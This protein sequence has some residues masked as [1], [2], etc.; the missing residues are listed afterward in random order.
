VTFGGALRV[1]A[2]NKYFYLLDGEKKTIYVWQGLPSDKNDSPDFTMS[3]EINRLRSDGT[4]LI[5]TS[6]YRSPNILAWSVSSLSL[7]AVPTGTV[8]YRMN[9]PQDAL[10]S[11]GVLFV[12]DTGFHRVLA[13]NNVS[14]AL[15]GASP[16]AFLGATSSADESPAHSATDL[17]WAASLWVSGGH[18]WVGERKFGHRVLRYSLS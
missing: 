11:N 18:L 1:A 14:S 4:W 7:N 8:G 12:A 2:D 9:L 6:L 3:A 15:A 5:G 16:D 17:R 13:W 10:V